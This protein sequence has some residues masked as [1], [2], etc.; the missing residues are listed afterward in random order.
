[1]GYLM[2]RNI[3]SGGDNTSLCASGIASSGE[4]GMFAFDLQRFAELAP[5]TVSA[6][7]T[8]TLPDLSTIPS[9]NTITV[10][11]YAGE[12]CGTNRLYGGKGG[13]DRLIGSS[14]SEDT[15]YFGADS[16][17][18]EIENFGEEDPLGILGG[19]IRRA[20]FDASGRLRLDWQDESGN[21][22]HLT[23]DDDLKD[24]V[25]TYDSGNGT[26]G[27][28]F[29]EKLT[30]TDDTADFVDYYNSGSQEGE[31]DISGGSARKVWLDGSH[32]AVYEG[33]NKMDASQSTGEMEL[34]GGE[35]GDSILGGQGES[36]LWGGSGGNDFLTG[37]SGYNEFYFG[38]GEGHDVIT[39]SNNGDKV[40]LYNVALEDLDLARTGMDA[41]GNMVIRLLDGSSLTI[42]NYGAQGVSA[43]QLADSTWNYDRA[44]GAWSRE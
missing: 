40:M 2:E 42:Q 25:I 5:V 22:S 11:N 12:E 38:R 10:K 43:F 3:F 35:R 19:G 30:V 14:T 27:A 32:G 24:K 41:S 13:R 20:S 9:G 26:H 23:F 44:S 6:D 15:F 4:Q 28:K 7:G 8:L 17:R 39:D 1:M 16:G 31:L 29:G 18:D 34:A 36:S 33:F 37:G 21:Q